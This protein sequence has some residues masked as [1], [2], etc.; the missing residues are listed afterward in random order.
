MPKCSINISIVLN[1]HLQNNRTVQ[2]KHNIDTFEMDKK[3]RKK[4]LRVLSIKVNSIRQTEKRQPAERQTF[5]IEEKK[6]ST[7]FEHGTFV[8]MNM[9]T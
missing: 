9:R 5:N 3:R 2:W 4:T 6:K 1:I 8:F 7:F